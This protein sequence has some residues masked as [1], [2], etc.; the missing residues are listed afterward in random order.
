MIDN[1]LN[2]QK[3]HDHHPV[4][5]LLAYKKAQE[6]RMKS[7]TSVSENSQSEILMY[8]VN[9]DEQTCPMSFNEAAFAI[10]ED[11][12]QPILMSLQYLKIQQKYVPYSP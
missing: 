4:E 11:Y 12:Y 6:E 8:G 7:I 2:G 9:I 3:P 1:E 5:T 10:Q